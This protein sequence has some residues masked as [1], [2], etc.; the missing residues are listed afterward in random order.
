MLEVVV[1]VA[2]VAIVALFVFVLLA[3]SLRRSPSV[4]GGRRQDSRTEP[5]DAPSHIAAQRVSSAVRG[6]R[7]RRQGTWESV[8]GASKRQLWGEVFEPLKDTD[9]FRCF[10]VDTE[11]DTIVWPTGADLAPEFLYERAAVV[12]SPARATGGLRRG[13]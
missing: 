13:S 5:G 11:L 4:P 1:A 6:A 3:V 2:I 7:D 9:V 8:E 10:R 12:S